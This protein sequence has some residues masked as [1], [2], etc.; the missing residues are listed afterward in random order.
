MDSQLPEYFQCMSREETQFCLTHISLTQG[1]VH[2][3]LP[4]QN[5]NHKPKHIITNENIFNNHKL[6]YVC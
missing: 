2:A 3:Q 5:D 4:N 1:T 6:Q